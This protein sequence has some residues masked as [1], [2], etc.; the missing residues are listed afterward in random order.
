MVDVAL[1]P[2]AVAAGGFEVVAGAICEKCRV[3]VV[4]VVRT[5][6]GWPV[7]GTPG[8]DAGLAEALDVSWRR[9]D[10]RAQAGSV[11]GVTAVD[12][13]DVAGDE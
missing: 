1:G 9:S 11:S 4:R 13:E 3:I 5:T 2:L 6:P 10:E 7:V 12:V 8:G